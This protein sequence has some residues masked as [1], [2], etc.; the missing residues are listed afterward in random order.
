MNLVNTTN[1]IVSLKYESLSKLLT[2]Q[3]IIK[4]KEKEKRTK[5]LEKQYTFF[6]LKTNNI[7]YE[8]KLKSSILSINHSL[9]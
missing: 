2:K 3:N 6:G 8:L 1:N 4:I 7:V 9:R 5:V